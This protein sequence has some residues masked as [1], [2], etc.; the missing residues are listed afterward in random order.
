MKENLK[1]NIIKLQDKIQKLNSE[2]TE[3]Q[4]K[5]EKL[6]K[7]PDVVSKVRNLLSSQQSSEKTET[8]TELDDVM[9]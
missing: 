2:L 3:C 4:E 7:F 6:E 1:S 5:L 8:E 9:L